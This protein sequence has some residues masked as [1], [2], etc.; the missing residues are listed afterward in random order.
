ML[1]SLP[2]EILEIISEYI[3]DGPLRLSVYPTVLW[4]FEASLT[5][6]L[7]DCFK[8]FYCNKRKLEPNGIHAQLEFTGARLVALRRSCRQMNQL[9]APISGIAAAKTLEICDESPERMVRR[10]RIN[11]AEKKRIVPLPFRLSQF[12]TLV[13]SHN[14][15]NKVRMF[16]AVAPL[17]LSITKVV[18]SHR[19]KLG[20]LF[21]NSHYDQL[22]SGSMS[23]DDEICRH[24]LVQAFPG[25]KG[26]RLDHRLMGY[27]QAMKV[28]FRV[29]PMIET[30][31]GRF[32]A[33]DV[34]L[35]LK[36]RKV[37]GMHRYENMVE[38]DLEESEQAKSAREMAEGHMARE[39]RKKAEARLLGPKWYW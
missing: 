12:S 31:N 11:D 34:L 19:S 2:Y 18:F 17:C 15:T 16:V 8:Y 27:G 23:E 38:V 4:D 24:I 21:T 7:A 9:L 6:H 39:M 25:T 33:V 5:L 28:N 14:P 29:S 3:M 20:I 1:T 36:K 10:R 22:C 37:L 35:D 30:K 32:D 26:L 13:V